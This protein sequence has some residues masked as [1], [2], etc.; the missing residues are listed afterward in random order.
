MKS[1][2]L[3]VEKSGMLVAV[4][5]KS[6]NVGKTTI[7]SCMIAPR[8]P[9]LALVAYIENTNHIP[10]Q[11]PAPI[12]VVYG[13]HEFGDV[14]ETLLEACLNGQS[15]MIDFGASDFNTSMEMLNQYKAVKNR[16]D[17]YLVPCTPGKKEQIDTIVTIESLISL[18]V[19]LEKIRI[20]FNLNPAVTLRR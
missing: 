10:N 16:V 15:G 11:I 8:L 7:G 5:N 18:G 20:L 4:I 14:E 19:P 1:E 12:G 6:G 13:A 2:N 9:N 17:V 3:G